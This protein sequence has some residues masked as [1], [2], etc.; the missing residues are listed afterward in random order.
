MSYDD[1]LYNEV[2]QK[3]SHNCFQRREGVFDQVVYWRIR[4][5]EVDLHRGKNERSP[6]QRDWWIYHTPFDPDTTVE[7]LSD[8]LTICGGL[9]FATPDHEV[10][11]LFLDLKDEFGSSNHQSGDDL[12]DLLQTHLGESL[13][14]PA[15]LLAWANTPPGATPAATLQGAIARRGG[16]PTLKELRG[17]FI[18]VLTG[19]GLES[20]LGQRTPNDCVAFLS[21]K[22]D[23]D[24][25]VPG[26]R[27]HVVYFNMDGAKV[28]VAAKVHQQGLV[29]RAYYIDERVRWE[30]AL[31]NHCHHIATDKINAREDRWSHTARSTGHPFHALKANPTPGPEAG[32]VCAVWAWSGDIWGKDDS[33][34]F[35]YAHCE[36]E[37]DN[38]YRF[39]IS[40]SNSHTDDWLKGGVLARESLAG[41]AAY[42]GVFRIAQ[43][44]PLRVQYRLKAGGTTVDEPLGTWAGVDDD[45]LVFVRLEISNGGR[46]ATAWGSFGGNDDGI[47]IASVA[48]EQ[49]LYYQGLGVS[50]HDDSKGAKFL[51]CAPNGVARPPFT[52]SRLIGAKSDK[53]EGGYDWVGD[54]RWKVVGFG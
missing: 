52:K 48:F 38:A 8:F 33:F 15:D 30:S 4:S 21:A 27:P 3:S 1:L 2:R 43:H 41:G 7:K 20:Y 17:K 34:F 18:V 23:A 42:F 47:R 11:T 9:H 26:K 51:F 5:L 32:E 45:T 12:D 40:G 19:G 46:R 31:A 16:W 37:P 35:H 22:V 53:Y 13:Y 39:L 25:D 24:K 50:A 36:S 29:S 44:Q 10:I 6:L 49:P 54:R 14:S 28:K